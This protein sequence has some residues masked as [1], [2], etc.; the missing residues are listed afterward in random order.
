MFKDLS[1]AF[2]IASPASNTVE[3]FQSDP[4]N[5]KT[6]NFIKSIFNYYKKNPIKGLF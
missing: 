4:L 6:D 3:R 1:D 5:I 2:P